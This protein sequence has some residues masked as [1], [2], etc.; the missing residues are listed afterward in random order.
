MAVYPRC[1]RSS[2]WMLEIIQIDKV[3]P[4]DVGVEHL[5]P[6]KNDDD[7]E[8]TEWSDLEEDGMEDD[9]YDLDWEEITDQFVGSIYF[10]VERNRPS[11][12]VSFD[13]ESKYHACRRC[14]EILFECGTSGF[15]LQGNR[16]GGIESDLKKFR[17]LKRLLVREVEEES[18]EYL[19]RNALNLRELLLVDAVCLN[20]TLLHEIFKF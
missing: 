20:H 1:K 13:C 2:P 8:V 17:Q 14:P 3:L 18:L 7:S 15:M 4:E 6:N 10:P 16:S 19:L 5:M 11:A 9:V 12:E